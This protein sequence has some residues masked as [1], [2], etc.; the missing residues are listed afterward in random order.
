VLRIGAPVYYTYNVE[1]VDFVFKQ[2]GEVAADEVAK[3]YDDVA[4]EILVAQFGRCHHH[5]EGIGYGVV[6]AEEDEERNTEEDEKGI[7]VASAL[8]D[9]RHDESATYGIG[10]TMEEVG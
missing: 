4:R 6:E 9:Y 3:D 10:E 5:V 7:L 1:L 8:Y 2:A